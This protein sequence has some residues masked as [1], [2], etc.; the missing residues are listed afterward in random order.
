VSGSNPGERRGGR[1]PGVKNK[2][3]LEREAALAK[4]AA[5]IEGVLG[6]QAFDGDAHMML[7]AVYKDGALPIDLRLDAARAAI[8]FEKPRLSSVDA[9]VKNSVDFEGMSDDE[10]RN[11]VKEGIR[12]DPELLAVLRDVEESRS[13]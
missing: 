1:Q 9:N 12:S 3:T 13:R 7:M 10:L 8:S 5:E 2:R 11:Y 6:D 4:A